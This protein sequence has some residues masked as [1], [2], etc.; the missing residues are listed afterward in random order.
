MKKRV[1][2]WAASAWLSFGAPALAV[3]K[4]PIDRL[5]A[6]TVCV[7]GEVPGG[8]F[9]SSG[10]VVGAG[11]AVMSTAHEIGA[12]TNLRVKLRDGRVFR[13]QLER[14]GNENA[15]IALLSVTG[16]KLPP[17]KFGTLQD[18]HTGDAV[19][20]IGCPLGFE[21]SVTSGV[22][23]SIRPSGFGYPL[24]Q[25][26]VPVN[27]GSSGGPLF[28]SDGRV[29]GIIKSTVAGRDR[30]HFALPADLGS[31][32]LYRVA[33]EREAYE[34]FNQAVLEPIL[35]EK[36]ELYRRAVK[37]DPL[38]FEAHYNLALT[39]EKLG[40]LSGAEAEYREV[41]RLRP[42]YSPASLN[43]GALLY[44]SKRYREAID[45][46][47]EALPRDPRSEA[48]QN[49]LA[50]AY[51]AVGDR[52]KARREFEALLRENPNYAPAHYG[53][54]V[55]YDDDHGDRRLAAE[56]YRRYLALAPDAADA[57]RVRQWL[58]QVEQTE[59]KR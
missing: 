57:D 25:T 1:H 19:L 22:V 31:A 48:L 17:V 47:R 27:P 32:L 8:S 18:V 50:E 43:L 49:N 21:F 44:G 20:T 54:A 38:L 6:S 53:L 45:V 7:V 16:L 24:I 52:D 3:E 29:V 5:M 13:A 12:A 36:L 55:L 35:E 26:D 37:L 14:L 28:D 2:A 58:R 59:K 41:L 10:F 34:A 56:H 23:S 30:I 46:Y 11:D 33:R 9:E 15:D 39:L 4:V 51:R 42:A 40:Q